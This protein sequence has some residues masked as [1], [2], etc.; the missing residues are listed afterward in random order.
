MMAR[1]VIAAL[2][3][4]ILL[5]PGFSAI[6]IASQGA[7]ATPPT[8]AEASTTPV[9]AYYYIW[10]T[11]GSWDRAKRDLPLL[12]RYSSDDADVMR[13]HIRWAKSAGI[14]GF[15]VSWKDTP[16]WTRRLEQLVHIADEESFKLAINYESLDFDRNPIPIDNVRSDLALIADRYA[17]DS[18]FDAFGKP[19]V[20][21]S[22]IWNFTRAEIAEA[23]DPVRD[24]IQV[25]GSQKQTKLYEE[26]AD[27]V[28]GNAYYW[29]SVD[30]A[31]HSGYAE[32][33]RGM[34]ESVHAH[35]GL[36]IA[37]AAPGFDNRLL[38]GGREVD[39]DGGQVL[40][41]ELRAAFESAPD[42]VGII[43]WNEFS[44]NSHIEPSCLYG[45]A[46]LDLTAALLGG[47]APTVE[48][49]CDRTAF[50]AIQATESNT[51]EGTPV[52]A[53][54]VIDIG[55]FDWDS[56]ASEHMITPG[57]P[58]KNTLTLGPFLVLTVLSIA[59]VAARAVH[60]HHLQEATTSPAQGRDFPDR[61]EET[62]DGK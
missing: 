36:W 43:S 27:L 35:G 57:S 62:S 22:G 59:L 28:D 13:Q 3:A 30:P 48:A 19:V 33:L 7:P 34:G 38:G 55:P 16:D 9:F 14:D 1:A 6:A 12:G 56:S 10:F 46:Y 5:G 24:R 40:E 61:D 51:G 4:V 49:S 21:W 18:V 45:A 58:L 2:I 37:P 17:T 52:V 8:I 50:A 25:L 29:S 60:A 31:T 15:L 23:V 39:R 11:E 20:V 44:E 42:A 41:T 47:S 54:N 53:G 26:I 32:K